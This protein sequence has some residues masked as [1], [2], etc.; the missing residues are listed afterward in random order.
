MSLE[1]VVLSF[2][3]A[4]KNTNDDLKVREIERLQS[5]LYLLYQKRLCVHFS[6]KLNIQFAIITML[7]FVY[8]NH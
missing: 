4:F 5:E 6:V 1:S 3:K 2:V 8:P 7:N